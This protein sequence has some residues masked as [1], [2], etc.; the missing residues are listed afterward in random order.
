MRW[1]ER[2]E[3]CQRIESFLA[4]AKCLSASLSASTSQEIVETVSGRLRRS[5]RADGWDFL[6]GRGI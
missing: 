4:L 2:C 5:E 3:L 1:I 6:G